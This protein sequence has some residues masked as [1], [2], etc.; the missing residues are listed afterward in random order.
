MGVF[1]N[2]GKKKGEDFFAEDAGMRFVPPTIHEESPAFD[3]PKDDISITQSEGEHVIKM[4]KFYKLFIQQ[5]IIPSAEGLGQELI[6]KQWKHV[7]EFND[8]LINNI[9]FQQN[10]QKEDKRRTP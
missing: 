3:F 10:G 5:S 1:D 9:K 8:T 2:F 4:A 7:L 6:V